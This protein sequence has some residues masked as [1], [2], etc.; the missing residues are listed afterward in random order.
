M[1]KVK[2]D[3]YY[4][5]LQLQEDENCFV[6]NILRFFPDNTVIEVPIQAKKD[7]KITFGNCFPSG[8][9]FN[10]Q[11]EN[12]GTFNISEDKISFECGKVEYKGTIISDDLLKLFS[13]SNINNYE[14]TEEYNFISFKVVQDIKT[15]EE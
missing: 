8:N 4:Y 10:E 3:G 15:C 6:N 5:N 12:K 1:S 13:H 7:N 14:T 2:F 9:G 11:Y